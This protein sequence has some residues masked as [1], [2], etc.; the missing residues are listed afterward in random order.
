MPVGCSRF[1]YMKPRNVLYIEINTDNTIGGSHHCLYEI[2]KHIDRKKFTPHVLFFQDH[3][4]VP[5]F[6]QVCDVDIWPMNAGFVLE[7]DTPSLYRMICKNN[8]T[9]ETGIMVQKGC[10]LI[11]CY[12]PNMVAIRKYLLNKQ[13]DL[14]HL[15]NSPDQTDWLLVSKMLGLKI[16]SHLR[17]PWKPTCIRKYLMKKYDRIIAISD[18][19]ADRL[20]VVGVS[21]ENVVTIH[22]GIDIGQLEKS[23]VPSLDICKEFDIPKNAL[24]L[25]EIGNIRRWKGQHV[26]IEAMKLLVADIKN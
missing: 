14:V 9:L 26:A 7:R 23:N 5:E 25:C 18:Y 15:N 10:N 24:I 2:V 19:V 11:R 12:I 22:D 16:V 1:Q 3:P 8:I 4:L 21:R 20:D 17:F 13:I 6:R